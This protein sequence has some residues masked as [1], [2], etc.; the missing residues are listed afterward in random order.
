MDLM[1]WLA[2]F[3]PFQGVCS[4]GDN[5]LHREIFIQL[6]DEKSFYIDL[7]KNQKS[8]ESSFQLEI[9]GSKGKATINPF[10]LQVPLEDHICEITPNFPKF[11]GFDL[12]T[13]AFYETVT[14]LRQNPNPPHQLEKVLEIIGHLT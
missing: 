8:D 9:W 10:H 12:Q 6:R 1:L 11:S 4:S 3:P 5:I 2:D 13:Q 14:K 7:H